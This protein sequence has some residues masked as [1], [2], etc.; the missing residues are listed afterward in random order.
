MD[1]HAEKVQF[2]ALLEIAAEHRVD[3]KEVPPQLDQMLRGLI[4]QHPEWLAPAPPP[5]PPP[6]PITTAAPPP[7]PSKP[8]K[9]GERI[10][11]AVDEE[12]KPIVDAVIGAWAKSF[13]IFH[14]GGRLFEISEPSPDSTPFSI[15]PTEA[16]RKIV[17]NSVRARAL[18]SEHCLFGVERKTKDN[19]PDEPKYILPPEWLGHT[20]ISRPHY[21]ELP[22]LKA[23]AT[24]PTLRP[25]G[26]LVHERGYE[27]S[28]AIYLA[29]DLKVTIPETPTQ[30]E[31]RA[32]MTKLLDI[33]N[34][35]DFVN[36]ASKSVWVSLVLSI[37]ARHT[38]DGAA[39]M[40]VID[41]SMRGSG[42]T[43]LAQIA[44]LIATG[45]PT[46]C[47]FYTRDDVEMD[48]RIVALSLS[49]DQIALLDNVVGKLGSPSLDAVLT[50]DMY[51]G[52]VLGKNEMSELMPMRAVWVATG[53][54]V[55]LGADTARR[56]LMVRL[57]P[58]QEHPEDRT[59]PRPGTV[60]KYPSITSHV[61][62][63][64]V[65]LLTAALTI[66]KAYLKAGRPNL[67][68][69]AIGSF[70][71][72]SK[73][74]RSSIVW[75]GAADP[76]LT[77]KDSRAADL[78]DFAL[79]RMV[80]CWPVADDVE[81]TA[82]GLVEWANLDPPLGTD[83]AKRGEFEKTRAVRELWR[84]ALLE[85]LPAKPGQQLPTP[86]DLGYALRSIK[87]TIVEN[88]R[89]QAGEHTQSGVPWRKT[90]LMVSNEPIVS[91]SET[92]PAQFSVVR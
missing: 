6:A 19:T 82:H 29:S 88:C 67:D 62:T 11:V 70:D 69:P 76:C 38:F 16:P 87:N 49:G 17:V 52:R 32:A 4:A 20:I 3:G 2:D 73:T 14:A 92:R 8:A 60:W 86:R 27:A 1:V 47:M 48:K 81:V 91:G 57:E 90:S 61:K 26:E 23:L 78:D 42:K 43:L 25:D 7:K 65:E 13:S 77:T 83:M 35:F 39:P 24:A 54:G 10:S 22:E 12:I 74:I 56:A 33:V 85:W 63:H 51:K 58:Q 44:S 53:N 59:G 45:S 46:A 9:L 37:V 89:V 34:D 40:I 84:N 55:V 18:A 41:A 66:V 31:A 79:K 72:W 36:E 75:A 30:S 50:S 28:M 80:A 5:S 71:G 68:L 15:G 21:K 64:R